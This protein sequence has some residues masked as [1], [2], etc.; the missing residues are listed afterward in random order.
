MKL[1]VSTKKSQGH[2][3][4]DF[5]FL[6][7]GEIV[8]EGFKCSSGYADDKCGC[9]RALAGITTH[10]ASTTFVVADLPFT[11]AKLRE[12]VRRSL[13]EAGWGATPQLVT[14]QINV[15]IAWA[16]PFTPGTVVE[17]RDGVIQTRPNT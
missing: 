17:Y 8:Y 15:M 14:H 7:E 11:P 12:I 13:K 6:P 1:L 2:R 4:S 16:R 9:R 3:E 10:K 5:C